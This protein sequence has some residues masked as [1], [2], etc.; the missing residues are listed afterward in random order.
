M[1][2]ENNKSNDEI[3]RVLINIKLTNPHVCQSDVSNLDADTAILWNIVIITVFPGII[4]KNNY[5]E[6]SWIQT[7]IQIMLK[8]Q[9]IVHGRIS[10]L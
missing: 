1:K 3:S 7:L 5:F 4:A 2:I 8:I 10:K 9:S 6:R